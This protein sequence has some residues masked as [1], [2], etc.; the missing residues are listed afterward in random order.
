MSAWTCKGGDLE[1]AQQFKRCSTRMTP[2]PARPEPPTLPPAPSRPT[3]TRTAWAARGSAWPATHRAQRVQR[4][5][6]LLHGRLSHPQLVERGPQLLLCQACPVLRLHHLPGCLV[7]ALHRACVVSRQGLQGQAVPA[8]RGAC[9]CVPIRAPHR[10][11]HPFSIRSAHTNAEGGHCPPLFP[12]RRTAPNLP[13][14]G[15][16]RGNE[17]GETPSTHLAL[18][19]SR[20]VNRHSCRSRLASACSCA[21]CSFSC[22][23][24]CAMRVKHAIISAAACCRCDARRGGAGG[25][26]RA[27]GGGALACCQCGKRRRGHR[28]KRM[29]QQ[30]RLARA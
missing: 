18:S 11:P 13:H 15:I 27:S 14:W 30:T 6:L 12:A 3:C 9:V 17:G 10:S 4:P 5:R 24:A 16:R 20:W 21:A 19:S 29:P 2:G 26:R 28:S 25:Q 8:G 23:S 1:T 7:P 22:S